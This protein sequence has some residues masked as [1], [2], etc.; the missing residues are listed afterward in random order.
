MPVTDALRTPSRS[1]PPPADAAR[2]VRIADDGFVPETFADAWARSGAAS[3]VSTLLTLADGRRYVLRDAV[4]V[5][6]RR[7]G[8]TDP[9]GFTGRVEALR[10]LVRRGAILSADALRLG[11]AV[12]DVE[13]GFL[14]TPA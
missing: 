9:Y 7:N 2:V 13:Y 10:E 14:A 12:Y 6:G 1:S 3:R 4:R 11:P 8:D 5:I